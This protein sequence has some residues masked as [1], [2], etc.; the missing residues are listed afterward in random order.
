M[1]VLLIFVGSAAIAG[2]E[3]AAAK[4]EEMTSEGKLVCLGCDLK[5][6]EGARAECSVY[7]HKHA[8]KTSDG[9]YINLLENKYSADLMTKEK[10]AGKD[11]KVQGVYYAN[12]N[13]LDVKSFSVGGKNMS[14]C[15]HCKSMDGC[16]ANKG[17]M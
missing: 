13:Q 12:A 9:R 14:W 6:A 1:T 11:I 2:E 3:K 8:L 4:A 7:G 15:D 5:N 17:G 10:Y 16:M